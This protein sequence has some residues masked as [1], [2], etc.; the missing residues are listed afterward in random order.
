MLKDR[1][2]F[3]IHPHAGGVVHFHAHSHK[4]ELEHILSQHEHN[5]STEFPLRALIVGLVTWLGG[6]RCIGPVNVTDNSKSSHWHSV[7]CFVRGRFNYWYGSDFACHCHSL[8]L[9]GEGT[10]L[11]TQRPEMCHW[12]CHDRNRYATNLPAQCL[13]WLYCA[14]EYTDDKDKKRCIDQQSRSP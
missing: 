2:H 7:Y 9:F 1:I 14:S 11:G 10:D 6:V 5:H 4:G 13:K 8:L 3:H 12:Y